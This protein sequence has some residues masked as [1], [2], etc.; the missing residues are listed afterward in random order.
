MTRKKIFLIILIVN[1]ITV[2][3]SCD[4]Q[5][6]YQTRI[7]DERRDR[8]RYLEEHGITE[9]DLL[10]KGGV[11]YQELYTPTDTTKETRVEINDDV[12]IYY[13]GYFLNG[14]VFDSNVLSGKFEPMTVRIQNQFLGQII[15][16]G[17]ASGNVITGWPPALLKMYQGTK[18]RI[19]VPSNRAYGVYGT[20]GIPGYTTLVFE[21]EVQEIRKP[22]KN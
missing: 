9:K 18:A 20:K 16:Q 12:V 14:M 21:L 22:N 15:S 17:V 19:V 13:T 10:P 6:T 3:T 7:E 2:F 1:S 8:A 5:D 11:Y 4:K